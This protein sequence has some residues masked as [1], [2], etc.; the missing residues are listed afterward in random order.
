MKKINNDIKLPKYFSENIIQ[1]ENSY[2]TKPNLRDLKYL[3]LLYKNAIEYYALQ[4][5]MKSFQI[6]QKKLIRLTN[7]N[8]ALYLY[9]N[10]NSEKNKIK[11]DNILNILNK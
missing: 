1:L 2:F 5:N 9:N 8:T 10:I 3:I 11:K 4:N 6:Y 7:S